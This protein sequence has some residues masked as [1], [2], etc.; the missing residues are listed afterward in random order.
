[1]LFCQQLQQQQQLALKQQQDAIFIVLWKLVLSLTHDPHPE[2][3]RL[4]A[5]IYERIAGDSDVDFG[6]VHV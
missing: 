3:A 5:A 6:V 1:M 2:L 4:A